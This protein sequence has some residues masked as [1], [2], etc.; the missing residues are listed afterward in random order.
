MIF[1]FLRFGINVPFV[2]SAVTLKLFEI[3][4]FCIFLGCAFGVDDK[5]EIP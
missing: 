4:Y 1:F 3:S 5:Y 2:Q